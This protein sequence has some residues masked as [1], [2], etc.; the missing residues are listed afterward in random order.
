MDDNFFLK[1][2]VEIIVGGKYRLIKKIGDGAFTEIY[3]GI[4]IFDNSKLAIKLEHNSIKYPQLLF[5]S[6]LLQSFKGIGIPKVFWAGISGEYNVMVMELLG[7]NLGEKILIENCF[8][9]FET[10]NRSHSPFSQLQFHS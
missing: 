2:K 9:D 3:E 1:R 4:D 10:N 8:N 5:E 6:K 7:S